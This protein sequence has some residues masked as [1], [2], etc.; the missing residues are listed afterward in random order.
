MIAER[1]KMAAVTRKHF[2]AAERAYS[3]QEEVLV[4]AKKEKKRIGYLIVLILTRGM[5]K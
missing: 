2:S 5:I 4:Y 1:N 3:F